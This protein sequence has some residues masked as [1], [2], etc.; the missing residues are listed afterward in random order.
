MVKSAKLPTMSGDLWF[1]EWL[2]ARVF[3]AN[4]RPDMRRAFA[5]IYPASVLPLGP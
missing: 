4:A 2:L 1:I 3:G 5:L